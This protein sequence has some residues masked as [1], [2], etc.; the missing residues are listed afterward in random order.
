[1]RVVRAFMAFNSD[2]YD[3]GKY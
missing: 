3:V 1:M 2:L